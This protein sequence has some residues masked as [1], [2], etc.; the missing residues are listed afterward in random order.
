[1]LCQ[2]ET[3]FPVHPLAG[4]SNTGNLP[5]LMEQSQI[6]RFTGEPVSICW[7][8]KMRSACLA[9]WV[10][11]GTPWFLLPSERHGLQHSG[12]VNKKSFQVKVICLPIF[13][14][15]K[16]ILCLNGDSHLSFHNPK[17]VPSGQTAWVDIP[18][19]IR[20]LP[21]LKPPAWLKS[22]QFTTST[23]RD[24]ELTARRPDPTRS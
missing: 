23:P 5:L 2:N 18:P 17:T 21:S 14:E 10:L 8:S 16:L 13:L 9:F 11:F 15:L 20:A 22:S 24:G 4:T 12:S 19:T 6:L 1:M 3:P 7:V